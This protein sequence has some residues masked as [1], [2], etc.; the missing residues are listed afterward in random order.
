[1]RN[2]LVVN[3][4]IKRTRIVSVM[5]IGSFVT[6]STMQRGRQNEVA[7]AQIEKKS[8]SGLGLVHDWTERWTHPL[9]ARQ[10]KKQ[11]P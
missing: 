2:Q 8:I 9:I 5:Y 10:R 4:S 1:M 6:S 3:L 7:R 11:G